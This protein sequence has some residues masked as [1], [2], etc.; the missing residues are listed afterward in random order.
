MHANTYFLFVLD[1]LFLYALQPW[2]AWL[3]RAHPG[4]LVWNLLGSNIPCPQQAQLPEAINGERWMH[5]F[6]P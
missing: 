4:G 2:D 6:A 5:N 1:T 3:D